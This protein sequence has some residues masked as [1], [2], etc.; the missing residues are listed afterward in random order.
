MC[1][2]C[3]SAIEGF[4]SIAT[5]YHADYGIALGDVIIRLRWCE[6]VFEAVSSDRCHCVSLKAVSLVFFRCLGT[7]GSYQLSQNVS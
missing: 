5:L 1:V 2:H 4:E 3:E 6:K 7:P